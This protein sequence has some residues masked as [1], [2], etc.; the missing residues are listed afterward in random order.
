MMKK[1]FLIVILTLLTLFVCSCSNTTDSTVPQTPTQNELEKPTQ[2][3]LEKMYETAQEFENN[4]KFKSAIELY[5]KLS[6]YGFEDP[7]FGWQGA[8]KALKIRENRYLHQKILSKYYKYTV[9]D[10]KEQLKDPNSL[11]VYSMSIDHNSPKGK[12]VVIFDYGAKNSFGGMVRDKYTKTYTLSEYEKNDIYEAS[13]GH[14]DSIG[15]TK[16]DA[17]RY[18]AGNSHIYKESQFNAIVAGTNDY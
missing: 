7:D 16:E 17:G 4:G 8:D 6:S 12:I 13:K 18:L 9:S 15:S 11:V 3:E 2:N 10:L 5:R 14:M 1:T